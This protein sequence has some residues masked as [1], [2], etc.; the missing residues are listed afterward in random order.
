MSA[1]LWLGAAVLL[2]VAEMMV[3]DLMLLMLAGGALAA[4]GT[5]AVFDTPVWVVGIVFAVVSL[6]L[7]LVVRPVATRHLLSR[8]RYLSNTEALEGTGAIVTEVVDD[9]DGRAK[10]AG[11]IWSAR[12]LEPGARIEPGEQVTVV[13]IDGAVAIVWR[14]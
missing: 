1:L 4:A 3:G 5:N 2:A 12:A 13:R 9:R 6:L 8:P 11:E 10:L 14:G 7:L